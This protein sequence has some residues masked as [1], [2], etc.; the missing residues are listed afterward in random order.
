MCAGLGER[1]LPATSVKPHA[2]YA[3]LLGTSVVGR[4]SLSHAPYVAHDPKPCPLLRSP[5][6]GVLVV[7]ETAGHEGVYGPM[8]GGGRGVMNGFDDTCRARWKGIACIQ[9]HSMYRAACQGM[10]VSTA[11]M[12][13]LMFLVR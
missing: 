8:G 12:G 5:T 7:M 3:G 11:G 1:V 4:A 13:P 6:A 2:T 10:W 9:R